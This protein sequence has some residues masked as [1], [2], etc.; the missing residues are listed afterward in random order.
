[1]KEKLLIIGGTGFIGRNLVIDSVKSNYKTTSL[2]LHETDIKDKIKT[3][4]YIQA[5][6]TDPEQLNDCLTGKDFDYVVNLSGYIDHCQFL[7][8]GRNIIDAHFNGVQNLLQALK[9]EK[10]KR[11]VQVG[12]SDE[13][14]SLSAPQ[15]EQMRECPIS[16]YSLGKVASTQ[17]LQM[18]HRTQGF[19][20]IILRLFLVYGPGQNNKR[21]L[22]QVIE[23]CINDK[24]F[25]TSEG[26]QLRD[27]CY[28]D[29]ATQGI[30]KVLKSESAN[31]EVINLASGK[32]ISIREVLEQVQSLIGKGEPQFGEFP[33]RAGENMSLFAD[34]S[35]A[36]ELLGWEAQTDLKEGLQQTIN[37][38]K[39]KIYE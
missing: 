18:L 20:V 26:G 11:F 38:Y 14:G 36:K 32:A 17:L 25:P 16:P 5:D 2:S 27:F 22:P 28:I 7:N 35:K 10:I 29:D 19:P 21:F 4:K 24:K 39:Q 6:I 33:Y 31:G 23:G 9:W 1:M 12:S 13:Y 37:Y 30:L 8:G 34:V 3:V 15:H